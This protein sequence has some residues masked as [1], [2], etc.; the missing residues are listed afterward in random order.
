MTFSRPAPCPPAPAGLARSCH[1]TLL[2]QIRLG[3]PGCFWQVQLHPGR[4]FFLPRAVWRVTDRPGPCP[5]AG[6]EPSATLT[7]VCT[8]VSQQTP[9]TVFEG[10]LREHFG[11][12]VGIFGEAGGGPHW[13]SP[14][15]TRAH[16]L[17]VCPHSAVS[18]RGSTQDPNTKDHLHG[19][20][21]KLHC[22]EESL[23]AGHVPPSWQPEGHSEHR[24]TW[25]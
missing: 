14:W 10:G 9:I 2:A 25:P 6:H 15:R 11:V 17:Q 18:Q 19:V 3:P 1:G 4:C 23:G 8:S 22:H 24:R 21:E 5:R 20:F 16:C 13:Q 12:H 7:T